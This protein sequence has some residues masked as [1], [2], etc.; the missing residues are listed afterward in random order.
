MTADHTDDPSSGETRI[1]FL[2]TGTSH[3][4]PMIACSCPVC[5]SKDPRDKRTR[6][7]LLVEL[8]RHAV[9]I[10]TAPE[11]RLQ[12]VAND[13]S[14]VDAILFTHTHADHVAGL[15][16]VRRFCHTQQQTIPCYAD[17]RSLKSLTTMFAYAFRELNQDY[18]E[19][20][21]LRG[22][23]I[24]GAFELFAKTITPLTLEHGC[25]RVLG[26]K[27]DRWAYCTDCSGVPAEAEGELRGL[28][29]LILD[30]LRYTPHPTHFNVEQALAFV[31]TVKPKRTYLT[32]ITHE[33]KHGELEADLPDGVY[34]SYDGLQL[35]LDE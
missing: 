6:C 11:L 21:K 31:D 10:D 18:S 22:V 8:G 28:D 20:P 29:V 9:L 16:D 7:S 14:R 26:F 25:D 15:D 13:V 12:C 2:G 24:E 17:G 32:H 3:G 4:I 35:A 27:I 19:R 1:T 5:R 34:L 23:A 30:A 33:I